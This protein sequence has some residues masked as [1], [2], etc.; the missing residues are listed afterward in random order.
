V[1]GAAAALHERHAPGD[2]ARSW[3]FAIAGR[4]IAVRSKRTEGYYEAGM[5]QGRASVGSPL[6]DRDAARLTRAVRL[7]GGDLHGL[8]LQVVSPDC[9]I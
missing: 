4:E 1:I 7:N 8:P 3:V 5:N 9:R 2:P 6:A